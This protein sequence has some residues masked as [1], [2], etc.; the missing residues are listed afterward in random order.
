MERKNPF[1]DCASKCQRLELAVDKD[2]NV[3]AQREYGEGILKTW[4][5]YKCKDCEYHWWIPEL[6]LQDS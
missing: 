2:G 5:D 3:K 1:V 6:M 4:I